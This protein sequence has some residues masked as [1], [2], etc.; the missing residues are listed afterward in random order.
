MNKNPLWKSVTLV[1][2]AFL[3]L[4]LPAVAAN[5]Q[6]TAPVQ[7]PQL[8]DLIQRLETAK[9]TDRDAALD[10]TVSPVRQET[11]LNQMNKADRAIRELS[12]GFT[13]SQSEVDDALWM[14][15]KHITA[16]ERTH[17]IEQ[18]EQARQQDDHNEQ[19]MLNG[20][21]WSRSVA[22][23]DTVIFDQ[24]KAQVDGVVKDLEIGAPVHWSDIKQV[25]LSSRSL[26]RS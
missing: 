26:L 5:A 10:P 19:Q 6:A 22:P 16:E 3:L 13:V 24:R 17:L 8:T 23:A 1:P 4:V 15:P 9:K 25:L 12:H 21:A 20:L 7:S 11:F 2:L 14:P 18:L